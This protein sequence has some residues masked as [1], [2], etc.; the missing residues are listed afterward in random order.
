MTIN[1]SY[2]D[3]L[4]FLLT[5]NAGSII[6]YDVSRYSAVEITISVPSADV[7]DIKFSLFADGNGRLVLD[8][9]DILKAMDRTFMIPSWIGMAIVSLTFKS[10]SEKTWS[11]TVIPGR[12]DSLS[13][14]AI[15]DRR[16]FLSTRPQTYIID[17]DVAEELFYFTKDVSSKSK[18]TIYSDT[19]APFDVTLKENDNFFRMAKV[20]CDLIKSLAEAKGCPDLHILAFDVFSETEDGVRSDVMRYVVDY[21]EHDVFRF[22]GNLG[23]LETIYACGRKK[24]ELISETA[25]FVNGDVEQELTNDSHVQHE[26][27]S[28]WQDSAEKVRFWQEFFSSSERYAVIDGVSRRIVVDE[29][30]SESTEGELNAFSFKWHYADKHNDPSMVPIRKELKQYKI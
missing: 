9:A 18:A 24:S 21:E 1:T 11:A 15:Y 28:G 10:G 4:P 12:S 27:F 25:G 17:K 29:I 30:D 16:R 6:V 13:L 22:R 26:T 20:G 19:Y 7:Q 2:Q 8:I 14:A 3:K 23:A 5:G